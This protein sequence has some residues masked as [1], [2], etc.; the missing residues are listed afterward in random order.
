[1]KIALVHATQKRACEIKMKIAFRHITH[2]RAFARRVPTFE[3]RVS[4]DWHSGSTMGRL[5]RELYALRNQLIISKLKEL[6]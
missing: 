2:G 4:K 1:M 6:K 5:S 3:P